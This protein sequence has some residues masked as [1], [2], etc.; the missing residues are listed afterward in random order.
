MSYQI[1][2]VSRL[3][4]AIKNCRT[5]AEISA[6][7]DSRRDDLWT[8]V[9]A[10][11]AYVAGA[12]R[13]HR[14]ALALA[15]LQFQP[16][17]EAPAHADG[18]DLVASL[19]A[20][21][22]ETAGDG[23]TTGSMADGQRRGV[24]FSSPEGYLVALQRGGLQ[25]HTH[26]EY[27][28]TVQR[29][30][31]QFDSATIPAPN[32]T[33]SAAEMAT[34][35]GSNPAHAAGNQAAA[36]EIMRDARRRR[37]RQDPNSPEARSAAIAAARAAGAVL[38]G[39]DGQ[40]IDPAADNGIATMIMLGRNAK[41]EIDPLTG[42]RR[43]ALI[44]WA[45]V[46]AVRIALKLPEKAFGRAPGSVGL[47]GDATQILN[48]GGYVARRIKASA[49][50]SFDDS[51]KMVPVRSAWKIGFFDN[52]ADSNSLGKREATIALVKVGTDAVELIC[53]A[54]EHP[55]AAAVIADY[56]RRVGATMIPSDDLTRRVESAF[57]TVCGAR[58]T[59]LG[60]YVAPAMAGRAVDIANAVRPILG[61]NIYAS[62]YTD[63]GSVSAALTDSLANSIELLEREIE[64]KA[65]DGK[66]AV[67]MVGKVETLKT[68]C[69]GLA[70]FLGPDCLQ[71]YRARLAACEDK[72][73]AG[74]D[75]TSQRAGLL[76]L[77]LDEE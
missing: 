75:G 49:I 44:P 40:V 19:N 46:E 58:S 73:V 6:L 37:A 28:A 50:P 12:A 62:A 47:L 20:M 60:L 39:Y 9:P 53:D 32:R 1:P 30:G 31:L 43:Q 71:D 52:R 3:C 21:S 56:N 17:T 25:P 33:V 55:G 27:L 63:R 64:R 65:T 48:H 51:S 74:L 54:P 4:N 11:R 22:V 67:G 34:M 76:E 61:R 38:A 16:A 15:S 72:I 24:G 70:A 66:L 45:N 77:D 68:E 14:F 59:D 8:L 23:Q 5:Q 69:T 36:A 2:L 18:R 7:A 26:A 41:G 35:P 13:A 10:D 57:R 42:R 29:A